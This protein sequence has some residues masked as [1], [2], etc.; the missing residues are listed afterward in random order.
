MKETKAQSESLIEIYAHPLRI[1]ML[2]ALRLP[3]T[4]EELSRKLGGPPQ[5]TLYRQINVLLEAGAIVVH[6][7]V[8]QGKRSVNRY[9]SNPEKRYIARE[10]HE[11]VD[12]ER[13]LALTVGMSSLTLQTM[14]VWADSD[15]AAPWVPMV[16]SS[17]V[18]L[19]PED[20]KEITAFIRKFLDRDQSEI[21][22]EAKPHLITA[23]VVPTGE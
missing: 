22:G 6:D 21:V 23:F 10:E 4:I 7:S 19:T 18:F 9:V 13:F 15:R 20:T 12:T 2:V 16:L 17:T 5:A 14:K 11:Q 1:Q 3:L 8:K